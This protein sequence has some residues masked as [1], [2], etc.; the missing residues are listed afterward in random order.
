MLLTR[1]RMRVADW[2]EISNFLVYL[3]LLMA[4]STWMINFNNFKPPFNGPCQ[5]E[6]TGTMKL[7]IQC[8]NMFIAFL[9]FSNTY[10]NILEDNVSCLTSQTTL[11][12]YFCPKSI[13][14]SPWRFLSSSDSF[15]SCLSFQCF[16]ST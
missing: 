6:A 1:I 12:L 15:L 16:C 8:L 4:L 11:K 7:L 13:S 3:I 14:V 5:K 2:D 9:D 10:F